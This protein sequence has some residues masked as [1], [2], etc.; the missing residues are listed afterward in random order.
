MNLKKLKKALVLMLSC[1]VVTGGTLS[2]YAAND[3]EGS[4]QAVAEETTDSTDTDETTGTDD[5]TDTTGDTTDATDDTTD[6]TGDTTD[7][8]GDTT[9]TTGDT[10]DSTGETTDT[11][12]TTDA[13]VSGSVEDADIELSFSTCTYDGTEQ[14]PVVTVTLGGVVL[15]EGTHYTV[16]Y[17]NNVDAGLATVTIRGTGN[18]TGTATR[19]FTIEAAALKSATLDVKVYIHDGTAKKPTPTVKNTA[20]EVLTLGTDYKVTYTNKKRVGTAT[21]TITGIGNYAGST[22]TKTY[23]IKPDQVVLNRAESVASKKFTVAWTKLTGSVKYEIAYKVK[24]TSTFTYKTVSSSKVEKTI[25]G[26]KS[27]KVYKVKVRATKT[28]D[29]VTYNGAWSNAMFITVR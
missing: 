17:S 15:T 2:V 28:R 26:L 23:K 8:T 29:G 12:G 18:C 6:S 20:G 27:G 16:S 24:G 19:Y 10:T 21:V 25:A 3:G 11:D 13:E 22:I 9:D 1:A 7:T 14:T 4:N 5:T